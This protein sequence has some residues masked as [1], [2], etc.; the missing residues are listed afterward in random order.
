MKEFISLLMALCLMLTMFVA[1]AETIKTPTAGGTIYLRKGPGTKYGANGTVS[2]GDSITVLEKGKAW[3]K[4]QTSDSRE[5]YVKNLYISGM[6]NNYADGT[7]YYSKAKSGTIKTKYASSTVNMR[8]GANKSEAK[9][10]SLKSGTKVKVLGK[11]GSWYLVQTSGGTAGYVKSTYVSTSGGSSSSSSTTTATV[12]N[13]NAV[14]MRSTPNGAK[15]LVLAK[16]TKVTVL[17]KANSSW[18][19]VKYGSKTGYIYS[20]YLK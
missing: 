20:K 5:G 11:N 8:A 9:V 10:M 14:N 16:G 3:T 2:N 4:I 13:C 12:K 7:T 15:I 19:K 18:W 1:C 17:S 6:G